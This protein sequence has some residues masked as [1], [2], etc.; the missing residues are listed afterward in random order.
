MKEFFTGKKPAESTPPVVETPPAA[1]S[2]DLEAFGA[3]ML[4]GMELLSN[5]IEAASKAQTEA[6]AKVAADLE[7]F[8]TKVEAQPAANYTARPVSTG[9]D[10]EVLAAC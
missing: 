7:A 3:K 1:P 2:G 6:T 8:K 10:G 9:G 5:S 4:K